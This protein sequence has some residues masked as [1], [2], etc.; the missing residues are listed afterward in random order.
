MLLVLFCQYCFFFFICESH[1]YYRWPHLV[2]FLDRFVLLH[3]LSWLLLMRPGSQTIIMP[4]DDAIFSA[5]VCDAALRSGPMDFL[6][7]PYW[8]CF[9]A[10][11]R[12]GAKAD[13]VFLIDGSWS[14]GEESFTK[15]VHFVY[16]MIGAF[17]IMGP[18][19]MQVCMENFDPIVREWCSL[20]SYC[21]CFVF[22]CTIKTSW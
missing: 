1:N 22:I 16:S 11:V 9:L 21:D 17:D 8:L 13:V 5:G 10:S 2:I 15:V 18:S 7:P 20:T 12:K 3:A 6:K 4:C 14:I 19:G